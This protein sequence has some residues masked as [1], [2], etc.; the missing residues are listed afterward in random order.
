MRTKFLSELKGRYHLEDLG[1]DGK[2]ILDWILGK[3]G[4][5]VQNK[6]VSLRIGTSSGLL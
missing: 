4:G 3:W 5:K 6:C 1:V 2:K